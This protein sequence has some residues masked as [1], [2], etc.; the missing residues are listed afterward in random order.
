MRNKLK[1][2]HTKPNNTKFQFLFQFEIF[3]FAF[4]VVFCCCSYLFYISFIII[5]III[6][7]ILFFFVVF[8]ILYLLRLIL[9]AHTQQQNQRKWRRRKF[10]FFQFSSI[11]FC[12]F[13]HFVLFLTKYSFR[14]ENFS[15]SYRFDRLVLSSSFSS[16]LFSLIY[17]SAYLK[18]AIFFL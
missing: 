2:V 10:I 13:F 6:I 3:S 16:S 18:N 11:M 7:I 17:G 12:F 8:D 9:I 4:L 15:S 14:G 1:I 5:I